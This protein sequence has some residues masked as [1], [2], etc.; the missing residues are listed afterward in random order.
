MKKAIQI[1]D[2]DN[3]ATVSS[4]LS[5]GEEIEVL[6]PGGGIVS[7]LRTLDLI[8]FG[9]KIALSDL[10][11]GASIVKYGEVIGIATALINVGRWVH[12]HNVESAAV[13]TKGLGKGEAA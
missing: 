1:D 9:H 12:V 5:A 13:P 2:R 3:V 8:P 10:E 6:S 4:E 11:K 7:R